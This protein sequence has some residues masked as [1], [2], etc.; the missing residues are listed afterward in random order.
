[1]KYKEVLDRLY[2]GDKIINIC[3]SKRNM[4][5]VERNSERVFN[6]TYNQFKKLVN[7]LGHPYIEFGGFTKHIYTYKK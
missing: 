6:L 4:Y 7:G 5:Y 1:M 3:F 2:D